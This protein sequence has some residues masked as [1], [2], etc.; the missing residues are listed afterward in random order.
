MTSVTGPLAALTLAV[1]LV[2]GGCTTCPTAGLLPVRLVS[3]G[4][5]LGYVTNDGNSHG[6]RFRDGITGYSLRKGPRGYEVTN[7][8]GGVIAREGDVITAGGGDGGDD[9]FYV[10]SGL[11][12]VTPGS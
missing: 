10:C 11:N 9:T 3:E 6:L 8:L 12:V 7:F 1:A 4:D 5:R 2:C